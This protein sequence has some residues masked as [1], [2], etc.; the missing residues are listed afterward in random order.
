MLPTST[1]QIRRALEL[2]NIQII[3]SAAKRR[4][5]H[6]DGEGARAPAALARAPVVAQVI[7]QPAPG[8]RTV[9]ITPLGY[10][11]ARTSS[12]PPLIAALDER[13]PRRMV[14]PMV[15]HAVERVG[16]L[17]PGDP[18]G[19]DIKGGVSDG[20]A[21]TRVKHAERLRRVVTAANRWPEGTPT[22]ADPRV[23]MDVQRKGRKRK[24]ITAVAALVAVV[25]DGK[26]MGEVLARHG[27][28]TH[29]KHRKAL[30]L[31][32]LA[33]LDDVAEALGIGRSER[34]APALAS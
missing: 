23:I 2:I 12:L 34:A 31:E 5:R 21:T 19:G 26:N 24:K 18:A 16:S 9:P 4:Q 8:G 13:D 6:G 1:G 33:V 25:V 32:V 14:V 17:A 22:N 3:H 28:S 15:V 7:T 30:A 10:K 20:G 11:T 27:W 29:S